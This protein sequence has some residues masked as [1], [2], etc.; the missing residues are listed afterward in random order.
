MR[1]VSF[2]PAATEMAFAL[3]LDDEIVGVSHECDF[4][5]AARAKPVVV[6][7]AVSLAALAPSEIDSTVART[8][9]ETGTLYAVD[10]ELLRSLA[11]DLILT[12]DLCQVC[13]PSGNEIT[14]L[15]GSLNPRPEVLYLTPRTLADVDENLLMIG[16]AVGR[17]DAAEGIVAQGRSRLER[18]AHRT[19]RVAPRPR[20]FF[21]EWTDPLY[22]AGHWVPEMIER[23]GGIAVVARPGSDSVRVT[24]EEAI[25][26]NADVVIIAPCGYA[27]DGAIEQASLVGVPAKRTFAVDG[28]SYFAR[29]GPRLIDGVELIA[30]LLHPELFD[31]NGPDSAFRAI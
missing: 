24:R 3:G 6:H 16:D 12:Q 18:I 7:N 27:L 21:A 5:V 14:R 29:P 20:V 8:L 2:L 22:C 30:H 9:H 25:A 28:N 23:A 19:S 4:P 26:A 17:R 1:I 13:A 31:W 10:E 15:L 11:P